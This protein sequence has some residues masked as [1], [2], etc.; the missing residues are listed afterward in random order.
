MKSA[1]ALSLL[2]ASTASAQ[3]LYPNQ[4]TVTLTTTNCTEVP[5]LSYTPGVIDL[6]FSAPI[7]PHWECHGALTIIPAEYTTISLVSFS[8]SGSAFN[9]HPKKQST[10][11]FPE[12]SLDITI[13]RQPPEPPKKP[14]PIF[15]ATYVID[16]DGPFLFA[17]GLNAQAHA[18]IPFHIKLKRPSQTALKLDS[19][20]LGIAITP[21]P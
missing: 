5:F 15:S 16:S 18:I 2:L 3:H 20:A 11:N 9:L 14:D 4:P 17:E 7:T 1:L 12:A 19:L 21:I 13:M 8:T 10:P 6:A